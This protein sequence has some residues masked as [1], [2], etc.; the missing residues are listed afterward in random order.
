MEEEKSDEMLKKQPKEKCIENFKK[1]I[2]K[3]TS[4]STLKSFTFK[5]KEDLISCGIKG[6]L[7]SIFLRPITYKIFL[8][9][10]P[11]EKSIQQWISI[12]FTH[13]ILYS[14]LKSKHFNKKKETEE[15]SDNII[16]MDLSRTF[17]E[18]NAFNQNKIINILY[19]VLHIYTKEF[20]VNYKQGMNEIISILFIAL[21]PYYFPST[22]NI[23]KIEI[24]NA[25]NSVNNNYGMHKLKKSNTN[26]SSSKKIENKI[27]EININNSSN[28]G[29]DILYNFFHDE[30]HLEVDLYFLFTNLM[31]KGFDKIYQDDILQKKCNDI[32]KNKLNIVD[33]E[34]YKHCID[35]NL[36]SE[37]F[38]EKWILSFF[39]RYTSLENCISILD[40]IISNEYKNKLSDKFSL[41]IIDNI[42]LAMLIKYRKELLEKNDEEFLIFCLCYPKIENI[43]EIFKL[44]NYINLKIPSKESDINSDKRLS[45]R[46]NPKKPKYNM[47]SSKKLINKNTIYNNNDSHGISQSFI[48]SKSLKKH[49]FKNIGITKDK[50][51]NEGKTLNKSHRYVGTLSS[52]NIKQS[53]VSLKKK[54]SDG[55]K[56]PSLGS[57]FNPKFEDVNSEDLID[58]YYF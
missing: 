56:L 25:I 35:I 3:S 37:V 49:I 15:E 58:L 39:D 29:F 22:K 9:L 2:L 14:Q 52:S 4:E 18:I 32:I 47:N 24:I 10:F 40:I 11:I 33:F 41:D 31:K 34:L 27:N 7:S 19:N 8:D 38:L 21:Y 36:G 1:Y 55:F 6:E 50:T 26:F 44:V 5:N 17:P 28:S 42:C 51:E 12:T 53:K 13:R 16:K 57:L 48:E 30:N 20:S 23:S 45:V 43:Q 46:I 54:E